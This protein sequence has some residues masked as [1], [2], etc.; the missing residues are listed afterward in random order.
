MSLPSSR[1]LPYSELKKQQPCES[2][3]ASPM[4]QTKSSTQYEP[5]DV[6]YELLTAS[7]YKS[8]FQELLKCEESTHKR[9]LAYRSVAGSAR[10]IMAYA[11][12]SPRGGAPSASGCISHITCHAIMCYT[13]RNLGA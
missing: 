1:L 2:S 10:S 11:I 13:I 3:M 6:I 8:K 7:N 9:I 4:V 5:D 12:T